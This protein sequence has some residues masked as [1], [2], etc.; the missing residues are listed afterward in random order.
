M[1]K[2]SLIEG[3]KTTLKFIFNRMIVMLGLGS[4]SSFF[5]LGVEA[6]APSSLSWWALFLTYHLLL[7]DGSNEPLLWLLRESKLQGHTDLVA[8][9]S[10]S[11]DGNQI[12][13]GS[14]D[15]SAGVDAKTGER[16]RK[17]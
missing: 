7:V 16:L 17:L 12:L 8:S 15:R 1:G 11:P 5:D 9:V 13:S 3:I 10:F 4:F 2:P 6:A 14:L